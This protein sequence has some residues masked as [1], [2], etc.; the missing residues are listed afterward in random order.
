MH[1]P[2]T[3]ILTQSLVA[4]QH[5]MLEESPPMPPPSSQSNP[6]QFKAPKSRRAVYGVK[7]NAPLTDSLD[8]ISAFTFLSPGLPREAA[9][10]FV[11]RKGRLS[12]ETRGLHV[13]TAIP[14]VSF[15]STIVSFSTTASWQHTS[16]SFLLIQ[17]IRWLSKDTEP[18]STKQGRGSVALTV[19]HH[20]ASCP[21]R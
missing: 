14:L 18:S 12:G 15:P 5:G 9:L 6:T 17:Q 11:R 8:V 2:G 10:P 3:R 1:R 20:S 19:Q 13:K 7:G 21:D 16:N 4:A